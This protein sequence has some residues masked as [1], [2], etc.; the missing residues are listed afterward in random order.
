MTY[1]TAGTGGA[2]YPVG[3]AISTVFEK[4]LPAKWTVEITGGALENPVLMSQGEL[5][6]AMSLVCVGLPNC[7]FLMG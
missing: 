7:C 6:V 4:Y 2:Y 5:D 3:V 1:G